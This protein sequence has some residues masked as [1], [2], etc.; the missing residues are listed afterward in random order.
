MLNKLFKVRFNLIFENYLKY[1]FS[2]TS[3]HENYSRLCV[4]LERDAICLI[5]DNG[6]TLSPVRQFDSFDDYGTLH[7]EQYS[8]VNRLIFK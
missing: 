2:Y 4:C 1:S 5:S 7:S 6:Q 8:V 3:P